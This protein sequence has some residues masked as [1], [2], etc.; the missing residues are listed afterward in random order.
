MTTLINNTNERHVYIT[1]GISREAF[2]DTG[3]RQTT[4]DPDLSY[5]VH[6]HSYDMFEDTPC[7][8]K[9]TVVRMGKVDRVEL[10]T[11]S[12]VANPHRT[13]VS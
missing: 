1:S 4:E 3:V 5:F 9:C 11:H 6:G 8:D 13:R 12:D 10:I 2:T 7:N